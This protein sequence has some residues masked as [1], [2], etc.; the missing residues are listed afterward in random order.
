MKKYNSKYG[1]LKDSSVLWPQGVQQIGLLIATILS[2]SFVSCGYKTTKLPG[3]N[4]NYAN[5]PDSKSNTNTPVNL[6]YQTVRSQVFEAYCFKCHS[7]SAGNKAG[8]NFE[9][10]QSTLAAGL[11]V[12]RDAIATDFMPQRGTLPLPLKNLLIS[13]IDAGAPEV[14]SDQK[15]TPPGSDPNS[16]PTP[17]PSDDTSQTPCINKYYL[18]ENEMSFLKRGHGEIE[19][20]RH[21]D[22]GPCRNRT[23]KAFFK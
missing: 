16:P 13:W 10:Y 17:P 7:Q 6:D 9:S 11:S 21:S 8:I 5:S 20:P 4:Y 15:N 3:T 14:A 1:T 2:A 12:I 23:T 22:D 18:D 19:D